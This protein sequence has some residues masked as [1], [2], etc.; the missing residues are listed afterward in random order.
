MALTPLVFFDDRDQLP[1]CF[2]KILSKVKIDRKIYILSG[3]DSKFESAFIENIRITENATYL[4]SLEKF[5]KKYVHLSSNSKNF[6][7]ACFARFFALKTLMQINKL[8][9]AWLL[10]TD[11][12]PTQNLDIFEQVAHSKDESL[13]LSRSHSESNEVLGSCSFWNFKDLDNFCTYLM[14][15]FYQKN[16][17]ELQ[18]FYSE[19][20]SHGISGGVCDM[21][22][23]KYWTL[24]EG[25]D[26]LNSYHGIF[27]NHLIPETVSEIVIQI[28]DMLGIINRKKKHNF[29]AIFYLRNQF[30]IIYRFKVFT[31]ASIHFQGH[32]KHLI[33]QLYIFRFL[34][35]NEFML[36]WQTRFYRKIDNLKSKF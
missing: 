22:A 19:L 36:E 12:W 31:L 28:D 30:F 15:Y 32:S 8:E 13:I 18:H 7:I 17:S 24:S 3:S 27:G 11:V 21:T 25:I 4:E 33:S 14:S 35:G 10:D 6:E 1:K 23:L 9:K 29:I 34:A 5:R 2:I 16:F 26:Y 20:V